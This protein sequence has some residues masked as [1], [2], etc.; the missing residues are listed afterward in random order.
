MTLVND[1]RLKFSFKV[2]YGAIVVR[3]K[4][5]YAGDLIWEPHTADNAWKREKVR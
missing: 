3:P 4:L 2:I 5:G 1:F